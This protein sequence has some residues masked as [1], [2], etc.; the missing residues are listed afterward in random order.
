MQKLKIRFMIIKNT[1][2]TT[3]DEQEGIPHL[4]NF[5]HN[6]FRLERYGNL[7][8]SNDVLYLKGSN[9][10]ADNI[11]DMRNFDSQS[12]LKEYCIKL[13]CCLREY[14]DKFDYKKYAYVPD[15]DYLYSVLN[16]YKE[17]WTTFTLIKDT[18]TTADKIQAIKDKAVKDMD[19]VIQEFGK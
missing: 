15:D 2:L 18:D 3:I 13:W 6:G 10:S 11:I 4:L 14:F 12:E 5:E 19:E 8:L 16:T 7:S 1:L 17:K 9:I